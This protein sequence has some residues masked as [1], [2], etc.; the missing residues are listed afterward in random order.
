MDL[1]ALKPPVL[2]KGWSKGVNDYL[3]TRT[4]GHEIAPLTSENVVF[5]TTQWTLEDTIQTPLH[6]GRW[7]I[8]VVSHGLI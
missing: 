1:V 6:Q 4:T 7:R 5:S 2:T 8:R 3:M